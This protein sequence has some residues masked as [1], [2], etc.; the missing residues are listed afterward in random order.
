MRSQKIKLQ[1]TL[2]RFIAQEPEYDD[3]EMDME[4]D[5]Q[6]ETAPVEDEE[7]VDEMTEVLE[8]TEERIDDA[9]EK[10]DELEYE[11]D[12]VEEKP[13]PEGDDQLFQEIREIRRSLEE[14]LELSKMNQEKVDELSE[15]MYEQNPNLMDRKVE[16]M[17]DLV[18]DDT[19]R[20]QEEL[21]I[22]S[23]DFY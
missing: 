1:E 19:V 8:E 5:E 23:P 15:L 10:I 6:E 22:E 17:K 9:E 7:K 4:E 11:T 14:A 20:T 2:R 3:E 21:G 12:D 18:R 13:L 16:E